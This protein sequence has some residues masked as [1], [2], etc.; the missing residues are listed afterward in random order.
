M[1]ESSRYGNNGK[2]WRKKKSDI[3]SIKNL[4]NRQN[5]HR[6]KKK[7]KSESVVAKDF[8]LKHINH[9]RRGRGNQ[10]RRSAWRGDKMTAT[11]GGSRS[12]WHRSRIRL[13]H[14]RRAARWRAAAARLRQT[15]IIGGVYQ[16][17]FRMKITHV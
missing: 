15:Y 17:C 12:A 4:K 5:S 11:A 13:K 8:N 14:V 3:K 2:L 1:F 16:I 10:Q 7:R 9:G 6:K